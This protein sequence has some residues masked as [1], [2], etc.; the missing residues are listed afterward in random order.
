MFSL[1]RV[2]LDQIEAAQNL[3]TVETQMGYV[4]PFF[5]LKDPGSASE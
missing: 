4:A 5:G 1:F 2:I 3:I